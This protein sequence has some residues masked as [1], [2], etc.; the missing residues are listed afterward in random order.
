MLRTSMKDKKI[1]NLCIKCKYFIAD[2]PEYP[3][4]KADNSRYGKCGLFGNLD[5]VTGV[6][7][8]DYAKYVRDDFSKCGTSGRLFESI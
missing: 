2:R 1:I 5:L 4:F 6:T 8:Y 7:T 3:D